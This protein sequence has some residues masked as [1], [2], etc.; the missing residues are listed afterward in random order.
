[1]RLLPMLAILGLAVFTLAGCGQ[2]GPLYMPDDE[3]AS[4]QYDPAGAYENDDAA[5]SDASG[6]DDATPPQPE[7]DAG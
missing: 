2:K 4:E 6:E 3:Q 1:M 7:S 5:D